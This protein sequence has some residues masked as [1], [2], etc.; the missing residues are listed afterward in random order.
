M[1][2]ARPGV[3]Q[4]TAALPTAVLAATALPTAVLPTVV[5]AAEVPVAAVVAVP[6]RK[7]P[8]KVPSKGPTGKGPSKGPTGKGPTS[9]GD[10]GAVLAG[11]PPVSVEGLLARESAK[12]GAGEIISVPV[13]ADGPLERVLLVGT[14]AGSAPDLRKAGAALARKAAASASLAVDLRQLDIAGPGL[15]ALVEG[16]LLGSYAFTLKKDPAKARV[17]QT[18]TLVGPV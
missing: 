2:S 17:L 14:G 3:P 15:R 4:R 10:D 8:S 7:V 16:L 9:K 1:P 13:L 5:L 11:A 12:G 6:T 18:I